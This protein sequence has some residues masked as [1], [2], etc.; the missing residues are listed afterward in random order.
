M[1]N[2]NLSFKMKIVDALLHKNYI[3][4]GL[5]KNNFLI[6]K[7]LVFSRYLLKSGYL[8]STNLSYCEK[9]SLNQ[10]FVCTSTRINFTTMNKNS[11][12][13]S[14]ISHEKNEVNKNSIEF[15]E[16]K[17]KIKDAAEDITEKMKDDDKVEVKMD[18]KTKFK[19][20]IR[21]Y[22]ATVIVFHVCISILSLGVCYLLVSRFMND[23][24]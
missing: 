4:L 10:N 14:K 24:I 21:D 5:I 8:Y 19:Q 22:G 1:L 23:F 11:C 17:D 13:Y 15:D 18:R 20:T 3:S 2:Q 7:N 6:N 12:K 9:Q 16:M